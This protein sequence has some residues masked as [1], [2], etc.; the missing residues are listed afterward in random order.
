MLLTRNAAWLAA[1]LLA[2]PHGSHDDA[3][4]SIGLERRSGSRW[5]TTFDA[6]NRARDLKRYAGSPLKWNKG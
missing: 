5:L 4:S 1:E 2:F 3:C 6:L